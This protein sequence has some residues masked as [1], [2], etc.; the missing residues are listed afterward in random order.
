MI[1]HEG[2]VNLPTSQNEQWITAMTELR[3][4]IDKGTASKTGRQQPSSAVEKARLDI[5]DISLRHFHSTCVDAAS[6]NV[7][8]IAEGTACRFLSQDP[9]ASLLSPCGPVLEANCFDG[10]DPR[11]YHVL[12]GEVGF[13]AGLPRRTSDAKRSSFIVSSDATSCL[14]VGCRLQLDR[15]DHDEGP[16]VVVLA[17]LDH[18]GEVVRHTLNSMVFGIGIPALQ[19]I[20]LPLSSDSP[21]QAP[22]VGAHPSPLRVRAEWYLV[23]AMV[24]KKYALATLSDTLLFLQALFAPTRQPSSPSSSGGDITVRHF[25]RPD[26]VCV[27]NWNT[28]YSKLRSLLN[29]I[30]VEVCT[31][32]AQR[33]SNRDD[34]REVPVCRTWGVII[35]AETGAC[36]SATYLKGSRQYAGALL[37]SM[38]TSHDENRSV[39]L[40]PAGRNAD[41]GP[42]SSSAATLAATSITD[43]IAAKV[44]SLP[45]S[46]QSS[47][48]TPATCL[49]S[50]SSFTKWMV[51][52]V[53]EGLPRPVLI[54]PC[55]WS[56]AQ[57][58]HVRR[59]KAASD[60]E[61]LTYST[62]PQCEPLDFCEMFRKRFVACSLVRSTSVFGTDLSYAFLVNGPAGQAPS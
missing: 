21:S 7:N 10:R 56:T 33:S 29:P 30:A 1:K 34:E 46:L 43:P 48:N 23:G 6:T 50:F 41:G 37:R 3:N 18:G 45:A 26:G 24:D 49:V 47:T 27:W 39:L 55:A 40:C 5:V 12:Q 2:F 13:T 60:K 8:D 28:R 9:H 52:C 57:D 61:L 53:E 4:R 54:L 58:E 20:L 11:V 17:H 15:E 42:K 19:E 44:L 22:H 51:K 35:C 14:V 25:L 16:S 38:V 36:A 59:L 32:A 31:E 62:T